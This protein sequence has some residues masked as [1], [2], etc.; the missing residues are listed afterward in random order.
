MVPHFSLFSIALKPYIAIKT[1]KGTR[2]VAEKNR[3][4]FDQLPI[5]IKAT[6]PC[7]CDCLRK[8]DEVCNQPSLKEML[9][10]WFL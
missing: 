9:F 1:M 3:K 5:K 4:T 10:V 2:N 8:N 7:H 6:K